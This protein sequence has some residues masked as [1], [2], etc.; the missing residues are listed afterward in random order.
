MTHKQMLQGIFLLLQYC[1]YSL[2]GRRSL[3]TRISIKTIIIIILASLLF[4]GLI[5]NRALAGK[6][7]SKQKFSEEKG[8]VVIGNEDKFAQVFGISIPE[9][10]YYGKPIYQRVVKHLLK[11]SRTLFTWWASVTRV[12][13]VIKA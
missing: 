1:E 7:W 13:K 11:S 3:K 12:L 9:K 6:A 2:R 10:R 8:I 4:M 5:R